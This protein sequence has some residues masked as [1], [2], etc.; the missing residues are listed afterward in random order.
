MIAVSS[1]GTS[2][3]FEVPKALGFFTG[4]YC[5]RCQLLD[6]CGDRDTNNACGHPSEYRLE[7][8]HP[9]HLTKPTTWAAQLAVRPPRR[10]VTV[11]RPPRALVVAK[12]RTF[13]GVRRFGVALEK[14]FSKNVSTS[15]DHQIAV[16][17]GRD[18]LLER[19]W[20]KRGRLAQDLIDAGY[21]SCISPSFSNYWEWS[22]V[23]NLVMIARGMEMIELLADEIPTIPSITARNE[24]DLERWF[25]WLALFSPPYISFH[26]STGGQSQT[27]EWLVQAASAAAMLLRG[28]PTIPCLVVN[29]IS[30]LERMKTIANLWP[31]KMVFASQLPWQLANRGYLLDANLQRHRAPAEI[32]IAELESRNATKFVSVVGELPQGLQG[33]V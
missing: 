16:L 22:G 32:S 28:S 1:S 9:L 14:V 13:N 11:P 12:A 4:A 19:L 23:D 30:T 3:R 24:R 6:Y 21:D 25:D 8:I 7:S 26:F 18:D 17:H 5:S 27:W 33:C 31:S 29:G 2:D 20:K 10:V 15:G